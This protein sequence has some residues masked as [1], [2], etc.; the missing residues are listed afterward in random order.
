LPPPVLKYTYRVPFRSK[1]KEIEIYRQRATAAVYSRSLHRHSYIGFILAFAS[2]IH[3]KQTAAAQ[4]TQSSADT[5]SMDTLLSVPLRHAVTENVQTLNH[6]MTEPPVTP[7][8]EHVISRCVDLSSLT[9]S[10]SSHRHDEKMGTLS[11]KYSKV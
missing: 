10:L 11:H 6:T 2:S 8:S 3:N 1:K 7:P 9:F 4:Y 5:I